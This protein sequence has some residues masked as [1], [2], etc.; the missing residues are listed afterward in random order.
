M[1]R[2]FTLGGFNWSPYLFVLKVKLGNQIS[3]ENYGAPI[4]LTK[5]NATLKL[6][7]I[8]NGYKIES[9]EDDESNDLFIKIQELNII[10]SNGMNEIE[11]NTDG[12]D[13]EDRVDSG[14][15][16]VSKIIAI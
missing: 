15:A 6:F 8:N 1:M 2:R 12:I 3:L 5:N 16:L 4:L 14:I 9:Y 11:Q 13:I 7:N 10:N